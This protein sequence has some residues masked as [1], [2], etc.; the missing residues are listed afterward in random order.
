MKD[1]SQ[2][3]AFFGKLYE[4]AR[5]DRDVILVSADMGAP[6]LDKFRAD[7]SA[8]YVNVGIAEQ[9]MVTV[10]SG[11]ALGGKTVF[12]YAIM[13]FVT[14]RC[15]EM[16]KV[17]LCLM[18]IAV[19]AVG[20]GSGIS[21]DDSGPTHHS[22]EDIA[23]MRALP[24]MTV[25]NTTDS[26]M[27]ARFAE[28]TCHISSPHYVRL[29]RE[30]LP[31][32]Y[33]AGADFSTGVTELKTGRDVCIVATGNMVQRALEVAAELAKQNITA[34]VIDL[35]R[36]KPINTELLVKSVSRSGRVV[37]LEENLLNGGMGS[38]VAEVLAD[39]GKLLPLKRI[40]LP[41]G[42]FFTYGGR[43]TMQSR[44]GLDLKSVTDLII[45]WLK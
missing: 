10:A 4:I 25:L 40:G 30:K 27:A 37:T 29:D 44:S 22:T 36:I 33:K 14:L 43:K 24:N 11:L 17:E 8:Q 26:V 12:M 9:N 21:Y 2:R 34:G 39:N 6:S 7:L 38:A 1:L 15:Y 18:N 5:R 35:Y 13:P 3:D 16:I 19:T 32:I 31:N 23:I 41:D 20:V 42:Y 45:K 28:M